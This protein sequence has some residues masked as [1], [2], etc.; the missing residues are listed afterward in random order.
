MLSFHFFSRAP[1]PDQFNFDVDSSWTKID[2]T[3]I[4]KGGEAYLCEAIKS[5]Y[6]EWKRPGQLLP[7]KRQEPDDIGCPR[8]IVITSS[9]LIAVDLIRFVGLFPCKESHIG[10]D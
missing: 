8:I 7:P 5:L 3:I 1:F 10:I 4:S 6:L 9:A 2:D